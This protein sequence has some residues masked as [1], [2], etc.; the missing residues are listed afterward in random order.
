MA[1][2]ADTQSGA[3]HPLVL[4]EGN[5]MIKITIVHED[6]GDQPVEIT[7]KSAAIIAEPADDHAPEGSG[8]YMIAFSGEADPLHE[9]GRLASWFSFIAGIW[10]CDVLAAMLRA[11]FAS[12]VKGDVDN[13]S[14]WSLGR[15]GGGFN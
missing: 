3:S 6:H 12:V 14:R 4:T 1:Q 15:K 13:V 7:C 2:V 11:A 5:G 10:G 8:K 9:A